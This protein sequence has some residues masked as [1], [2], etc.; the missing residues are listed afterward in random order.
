MNILDAVLSYVLLY[1]Y[2]A[3][4]ILVYSAAVILPL[5]GNAMLLAVGAFASQG[6][7][8]FWEVLAVA[9]SANTLGDITD[10][11]LTRKFGERI[12]RALR[13]HKFKFYNQ[14][15]EELR[16]DAAVTVFTTRFAGSLSPVACLLAGLVGVPFFP[17]FFVNDLLGNFIEP[18]AAL[19]I[20]YLVGGYWNNFS[21]P[22]E[23]VA[24]IVAVAVVMFVLFRIYQRMAR[25]RE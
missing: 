25:R 16:A 14:L 19:T 17:T 21:D 18:F 5:P 8:N 11:A 6:Y 2:A 15:Q 4:G 20:G 23:L 1:K 7:I 13:L 10:Y 3:V 12:I 24:A 9:V 22:L